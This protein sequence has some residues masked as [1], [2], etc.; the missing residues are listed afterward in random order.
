MNNFKMK[1]VPTRIFAKDSVSTGQAFLQ[2]ELEKYVAEVNMPLGGFFWN[3]DISVEY[4]GGKLEY[5]RSNGVTFGTAGQDNNS[6]NGG[7]DTEIPLITANFAVERFKV[8]TKNYKFAVK[9]IDLDK[10]TNIGRDIQ[11]LLRE[12]VQLAYNKDLDKIAF[13]GT[14]TN[15]EFGLFN[16]PN[17]FASSLSVGASGSTKWINKTPD[18]ILKDINNIISYLQNNVYYDPS[19]FPDTMLVSNEAYNALQ[20]IVSSAGNRSILDYVL[21]NNT[22]VK[23]GGN[24]NILPNPFSEGKGVGGTNRIVTYNSNYRFLGLDITEPLLPVRTDYNPDKDTFDTLYESFVS[25][26][27][28]N[29]LQTIVYSDGV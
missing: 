14:P 10:M 20:R 7:A 25:V 17:V 12:G 9:R 26:M 19:G 27:K 29:A 18:E 13:I 4:G 28:F 3:R 1:K 2:G 15:Q 5:T 8:N 11:G 24:F 21:E 22:I 23:Q 16:N 6:N